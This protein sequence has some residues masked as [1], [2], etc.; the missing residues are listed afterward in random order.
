LRQV[1]E[2]KELDYQPVAGAIRRGKRP[3][4][5]DRERGQ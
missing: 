5:L 3:P 2:G 4:K 1:R